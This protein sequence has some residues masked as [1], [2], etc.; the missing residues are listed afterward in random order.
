MPW[1]ELRTVREW[2]GAFEAV[3]HEAQRLNVNAVVVCGYVRDRLLASERAVVIPEVDI[4]VVDRR[5]EKAS[6]GKTLA[7]PAGT[8]LNVESPP[9]FFTHFG[10]PHH[11]LSTY[12]A[13]SLAS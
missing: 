12:L 11:T 13:L 9:G 4:V 7:H 3:Q 6:C 8:A 10:T 1:L 2:E 5:S